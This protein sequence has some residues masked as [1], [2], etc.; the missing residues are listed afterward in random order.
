ME[1][2]SK[3]KAFGKIIRN[4]SSGRRKKYS[5]HDFTLEELQVIKDTTINQFREYLDIRIPNYLTNST[6][7]LVNLAGM[8]NSIKD[9]TK[10][11]ESVCTWA[12]NAYDYMVKFYEAD[13]LNYK[14]TREKQKYSEHPTIVTFVFDADDKRKLH[15]KWTHYD[16]TVFKDWKDMLKKNIG[17]NFTLES[18][19][20]KV[21]IYNIHVRSGDDYES[22]DDYDYYDFEYTDPYEPDPEEY[23]K[24]QYPQQFE[25]LAL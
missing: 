14:Y 21:R 18:Y 3:L 9:K 13:S 22:D 8:N 23:P 16:F 2:S 19:P 15:G 7:G 10:K 25:V 20:E 17:K 6:W 11:F 5:P 4:L 1:D 24:G 12:S